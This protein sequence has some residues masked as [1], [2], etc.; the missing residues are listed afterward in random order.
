MATLTA[1][2]T[3][4]LQAPLEP[5]LELPTVGLMGDARRLRRL[6][7]LLDEWFEIVSRAETVEM[8]ERRARAPMEVAVLVGG[9]ELWARGGAFERLGELSPSPLIVVVASDDQRSLVRKALNAGAHG[10]VCERS[11]ESALLP[12]IR[13]VLN[14]QLSVPAT[15]RSRTPWHTLSLRERQVL[16]HVADGLTN[17]EIARCLHL[18]ESTVKSHLSTSF[19]KLGVSS[20]AEAA[21]AVLDPEDGLDACPTL[22]PPISLEQ[23]LL[24][25][26]A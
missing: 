25:A 2:K 20:R 4:P 19:R 13:A 16:K 6:E 26:A 9:T 17:G 23:R 10:F 5:V 24:G 14:G 22:A 7:A 8:L 1:T 15:I 11:L 21:A 18:S 3:A 12:S